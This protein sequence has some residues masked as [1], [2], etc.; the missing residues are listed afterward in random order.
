MIKSVRIKND[1]VIFK[2]D[3]ETC[4]ARTVQDMLDL[5]E[6]NTGPM[7]KHEITA[8][9]IVQIK[10]DL[11]KDQ[12]LEEYLTLCGHGVKTIK[13]KNGNMVFHGTKRR[14]AALRDRI[15]HDRGIDI[16]W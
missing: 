7:A 13:M 12:L 16:P 2:F 3:D 1:I 6:I 11:N 9:E 10:A 14:I 4:V 5:L 8:E 15:Q